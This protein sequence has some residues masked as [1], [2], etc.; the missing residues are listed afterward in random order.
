MMSNIIHIDPAKL[1]IGMRV[2]VAFHKM[3]DE[4]T[5]PYFQ[6]VSG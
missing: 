2:E 6:P 3:S 5:M 1:A 4:I